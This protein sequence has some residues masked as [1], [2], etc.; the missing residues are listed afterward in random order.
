MKLFHYIKELRADAS[1]PEHMRVLLTLYWRVLLWF[2]FIVMLGVFV[3]GGGQILGVMSDSSDGQSDSSSA[4][5]TPSAP[6]NSTQVDAV[7]QGFTAR[8]VQFD[9]Y[10]TNTTP[11]PDPAL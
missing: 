1:E 5:S 3:Y 8:Q 11:I 2:V 6:I 9:A 7:L 4:T 10:K